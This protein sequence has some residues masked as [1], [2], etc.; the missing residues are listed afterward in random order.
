MLSPPLFQ[1]TGPL[2]LATMV[3]LR[4]LSGVVS[5]LP[6]FL[7]ATSIDQRVSSAPGSPFAAVAH[8]ADAAD[9]VP[10][11]RVHSCPL[12]VA[13]QRRAAP[14]GGRSRS[15]AAPGVVVLGKQQDGEGADPDGWSD[16]CQPPPA[17]ED[18]SE[19]VFVPAA[20]LPVLSTR[21]PADLDH[22]ATALSSPVAAVASLRAAAGTQQLLHA[23][24]AA[25]PS[26]T[27]AVGGDLFG[28]VSA[29]ETAPDGGTGRSST[30]G[31]GV[32]ESADELTLTLPFVSVPGT[33]AE[34]GRDG[35]GGCS[36]SS[37][38]ATGRLLAAVACPSATA[39]AERS[40]LGHDPATQLADG[41]D[42]DGG[43][44]SVAE[45]A[46]VVVRFSRSIL[47]AAEATCSGMQLLPATATCLTEVS[48]SLA[49]AAVATSC[50]TAL[51]ADLG[52]RVRGGVRDSFRRGLFEG[53][54]R[55]GIPRSSHWEVCVAGPWARLQSAGV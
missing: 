39:V 19:V 32:W 38:T 5:S 23:A 7:L 15:R 48:G 10:D 44:V 16:G 13:E 8:I 11:G 55:G 26:V 22:L 12:G 21:A 33:A 27:A 6:A 47:E 49:T 52:D 24:S 14:A 51:A 36:S 43:G 40:R 20:S 9:T 41:G 46:V 31:A 17:D 29:A 34:D 4:P 50:E 37:R 30:A 54:V 45:S 25:T 3:P 53:T 42:L 28:R 18:A 35:G 2:C 1:R